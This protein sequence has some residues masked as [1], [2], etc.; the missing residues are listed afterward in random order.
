MQPKMGTEPSRPCLP[1]PA[2]APYSQILI[3]S[4]LSQILC[5]SRVNSFG[6]R[7]PHKQSIPVPE[8][9]SQPASQPASVILFLSLRA[10]KFYARC[11]GKVEHCPSVKAESSSLAL[12]KRYHYPEGLTTGVCLRFVACSSFSF[13]LSSRITIYFALKR[14]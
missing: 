12:E 1:V 2:S 7:L 13:S 6:P 10:S 8:P 3:D 9:A 5:A 4:A 11:A 14:R